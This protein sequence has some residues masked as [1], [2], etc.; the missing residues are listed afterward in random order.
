MT[1]LQRLHCPNN[2]AGLDDPSELEK[3]HELLLDVVRV[4][5]SCILSRGPQNLQ[6][7]MQGRQFLAENR[8]LAVAIF[9]RHAD[10]GGRRLNKTGDLRELV[11]VFVLLFTIT[12]FVEVCWIPPSAYNIMMLNSGLG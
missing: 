9:K 12:G 1:S 11:D 8:N 3:Y 6:T 5:A 7:M 4:V 10:I 2:L